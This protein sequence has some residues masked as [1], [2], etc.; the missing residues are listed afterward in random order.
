VSL[1]DV[2]DVID[3]AIE[4]AEKRANKKLFGSAKKKKVG[5]KEYTILFESD[6]K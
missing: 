1:E 6:F 4:S 3:T 2:R 5:N